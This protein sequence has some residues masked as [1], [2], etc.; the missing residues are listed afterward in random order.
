MLNGT[1]SFIIHTKTED[2]YKDSGDDVK[3]WF[4]TSNYTEDE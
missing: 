2:F 1:H 4:G 3:K